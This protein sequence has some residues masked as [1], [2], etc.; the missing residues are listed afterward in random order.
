MKDLKIPDKRYRPEIEGV[1]TVATLLVAIY[2]IWLGRVSGGIDVFF[3]LSGFLITTSLLLRVER[4]GQIG[5][6]SFLLGLAKRLFPQALFV[7]LV[8]TV[9]A[10]LIIPQAQWIQIVEHL[11]ASVL[12]VENWRLAV[13][14]VDYLAQGQQASPFQHFWSLSV[15]GQFYIV[16]PVLI[17]ITYVLARKLLKTPVRKTLLA[18]LSLA[19][20]VS[21]S[22]SVYKT[23]TNQPWAYFDTF[24]RVWEFSIGGIFALLLPYV[25]LNKWVSTVTGWLGLGVICFTG[26]V[27]QVSTVFPGYMA[28]VPIGGALLVLVAS[29]NST[30]LGVDRF[31]SLKLFTILGGL[32]YGFYLWHWPLLCFYQV[33]FNTTDVSLL[34]GSYILFATLVLSYISTRFIEKPIRKLDVKQAKRKVVLVLAMF[35]LPVCIA[36]IALDQ[37]IEQNETVATDADYPGAAA[38]YNGI[39]PPDDVGYFPSYI[40]V[41]N[42]FPS[43]YADA[44]CL[45]KDSVEVKVCSYGVTENPDYVLALVGGS[46]SGHWFPALELLAQELNFR[47]DL[48]N[49]DGCRFTDQ[50]PDNHL[51]ENCLEWNANLIKELKA[52]PPDL[53]FTTASLNKR[54]HVPVGYVGQWTKLEDV[55]TIFAIRDNPRMNEIAPTCLEREVDA[56]N[57]GVPRDEALSTVVPWENTEGLPSNVIYADLSDY[58]CDEE[59]CPA[60]IGNVIVYRDDNHLTTAYVKT[61]APVLKLH[62]ETA[63][64]Q[65]SK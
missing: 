26:V 28:L 63:F 55:T 62:L 4:T 57:C 35:L 14:A 12:Y 52:D 22:Y 15:Q 31:L 3:V 7:T 27:L 36:Y 61:L 30:K 37:Y 42:D 56:T 46:H 25:A 38:I 51:T 64:E 18:V 54:D 41:V 53:V 50:D 49:H 40:N 44:H 2:H 9:L 6:W 59:S 34:H 24:A 65:L 16:W 58:F 33:Y 43:F 23:N 10:V 21:I 45:G 47:L 8:T 13:D 5:F 19:F 39:Q 11:V 32:T 29:E 48:Y 17:Y 20:V 1:R 60:V